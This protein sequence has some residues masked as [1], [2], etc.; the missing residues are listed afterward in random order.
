ME[1]GIHPVRL[2]AEHTVAARIGGT[3]RVFLR[4]AIALILIATAVGKFLDLPGFAKVLGTYQAFEEWVLLPL[5]ILIPTVEILLASW[6]V[7]GRRLY[8]AAL[9]SAALHMGYALWSAT[10]ILRGL[11]LENCGCF[12]V[13][14]ARPLRWSTVLEDLVLVGISLMLAGLVRRGR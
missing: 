1:S 4:F 7:A 12:G 13:F 11:R 5:A 3:A 6:L 8:A 14:L 9:V 2:G 10:S